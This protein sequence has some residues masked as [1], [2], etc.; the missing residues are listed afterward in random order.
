MEIAY[1]LHQ[2]SD[3]DSRTVTDIREFCR[4]LRVSIL[5]VHR[6][7]FSIEDAKFLKQSIQDAVLFNDRLQ[8]PVTRT[9]S[10]RSVKRH[11]Q[12]IEHHRRPLSNPSTPTSPE[13][14]AFNRHT[15]V[16]SPWHASNP[17][18][19]RQNSCHVVNHHL[20][21]HWR[22]ISFLQKTSGITDGDLLGESSAPASSTCRSISSSSESC[23]FTQNSVIS[24]GNIAIDYL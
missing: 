20:Q 2:P 9:E 1:V 6:R 22:R 4:N 23:I 12:Y 5:D 11:Q 24:D 19:E 16:T 10:T 14:S 13:Y 8:L 18:P 17:A 7:L 15:N 21:E 3:S